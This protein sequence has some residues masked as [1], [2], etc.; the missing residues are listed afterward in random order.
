VGFDKVYVIYREFKYAV[1][2][3]RTALITRGL[4]ARCHMTDVRK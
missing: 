2:S 1:T 3:P 4:N